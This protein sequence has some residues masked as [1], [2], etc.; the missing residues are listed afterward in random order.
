MMAKQRTQRTVTT[1]TT[2][3]ITIDRQDILDFLR[4]KFPGIPDDAVV[5]FDVPGGGSWSNMSIDISEDTPIN[6]RWRT[7]ATTD[8]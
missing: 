1:T 8:L 2:T 7:E 6:V 4:Q 5:E 3:E